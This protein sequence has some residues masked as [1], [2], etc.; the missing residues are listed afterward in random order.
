M[1]GISWPDELFVACSSSF[2]FDFP[3]L[4]HHT[5]NIKDTQIKLCVFLTSALGESESITLQN[6]HSQNIQLQQHNII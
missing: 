1:K 6:T 2:P 3:L 4:M 5:M